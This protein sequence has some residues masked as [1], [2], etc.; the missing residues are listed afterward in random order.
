MSDVL[1]LYDETGSTFHYVDRF[2]F[3]QVSFEQ[4]GQQMAHTQTMQL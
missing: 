3:K 2:G 4:P 1:E